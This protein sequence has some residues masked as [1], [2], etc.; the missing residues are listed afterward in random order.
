MEQSPSPHSYFDGRSLG[1]SDDKPSKKRNPIS[2]TG[3]TPGASHTRKQSSPTVNEFLLCPHCGCRYKGKSSFTTHLRKKHPDMHTE[4]ICYV[5][6][7]NVDE[8]AFERHFHEH[9]TVEM[10][11]SQSS[12]RL[13]KCDF[14]DFTCTL[15]VDMI[16]HTG[17]DHDG[18]KVFSMARTQA[19][20]LTKTRNSKRKFSE[21]DSEKTMSG[22]EAPE[23]EREE[24]LE[25]SVVNMDGTL[26]VENDQRT[27]I[28]FCLK[29]GQS[30]FVE[31]G[32]T[33][34]MLHHLLISPYER[35]WLKLLV[36]LTSKYIRLPIEVSSLAQDQSQLTNFVIE[37]EVPNSLK[38]FFLPEAW[39]HLEFIV[40]SKR[41][42]FYCSVCRSIQ[43][44]RMIQCTACARR[45]HHHCGLAAMIPQATYDC[46]TCCL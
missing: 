39:T 38:K 26:V 42:Q 30:A 18:N 17:I 43:N 32:F 19:Q 10:R 21:N 41:S 11:Q 27:E 15:D 7:S 22:N 40:G 23:V 35:S 3:S 14:C 12:H 1:S 24:V 2:Q 29:R 25:E 13:L 8:A 36:N 6:N 4:V 28:L 37:N 45:Y 46:A 20:F 44:S 5:C 34:V 33:E 9:R 31:R 16:Q